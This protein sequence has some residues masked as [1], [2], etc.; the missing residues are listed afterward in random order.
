MCDT[1]KRHFNIQEHFTYHLSISPV[2][3]CPD[4]STSDPDP[5]DL[6]G[7]VVVVRGRPSRVAQNVRLPAA[8]D[9]NSPRYRAVQ[10]RR[11]AC[12]AADPSE[13]C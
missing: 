1:L 13:G 9:R 7:N 2:P 11:N 12:E 10:H 4:P 5:P 6:S 8:R 3:R